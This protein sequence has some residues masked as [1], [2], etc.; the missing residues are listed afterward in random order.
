[1]RC[2][3]LLVAALALK[4]VVFGSTGCIMPVRE[5]HIMLLG[6]RRPLPLCPAVATLWPLLAASLC[7]AGRS[8]RL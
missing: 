1:M 6:V 3:D 5:H 7:G 2:L 8:S 4:A